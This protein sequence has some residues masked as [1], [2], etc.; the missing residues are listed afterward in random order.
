MP[1]ISDVY[2]TNWSTTEAKPVA[3]G[4][5]RTL[6]SESLCGSKTLDVYQRTVLEGRQLD[7]NAGD[8]CH[9]VY[10]VNA[11]KAGRIIFNGKTHAAEEGAGR[12]HHAG[13]CLRRH[14]GS[15]FA[16]SWI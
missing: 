11:P 5:E 6:C 12:E 1:T 14:R 15:R 9:L 13:T 10:V 4:L 2:I 16:S 8:D 3:S 7:V